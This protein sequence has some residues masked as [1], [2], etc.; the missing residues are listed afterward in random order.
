[1]KIVITSSSKHKVK[2]LQAAIGQLQ[3]D[4]EVVTKAGSSNINAQPVG[5]NETRTGAFNRT[6]SCG[7]NEEDLVV[8]IENGLLVLDEEDEEGIKDFAIVLVARGGKVLVWEMSQTVTFPLSQ[9]DNAK[10]AGFAESTVGD[11]LAAERVVNDGTDPHFELGGRSRSDI[12]RDTVMVC[13]FRLDL[14]K[15]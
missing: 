11:F 15:S 5:I 2:A 13:L 3:I 6:V 1:M 12:L 9:Y 10:A 14:A 7:A 8:S 4:A